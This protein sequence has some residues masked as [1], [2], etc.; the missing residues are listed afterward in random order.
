ME[1]F[2]S[3]FLDNKICKRH[4]CG[5]MA[6]QDHDVILNLYVS[7]EKWGTAL[8]FVCDRKE[9]QNLLGCYVCERRKISDFCENCF[10]CGKL[11]EIRERLNNAYFHKKRTDSPYQPVSWKVFLFTFRDPVHFRLEIL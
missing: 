10:E 11:N 4:D 1:Y 8:Y 2:N 3:D 9:L 6:C 5:S 7:R